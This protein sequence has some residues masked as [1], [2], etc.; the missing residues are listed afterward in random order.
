MQVNVRQLALAFALTTAVSSCD[1]SVVF[2]YAQKSNVDSEQ[3][4]RKSHAAWFDALLAGDTAAL[5]QLLAA[6]VTLAFPGGNLMPRA[7]FLSYLKSGEL[8]YDTAE[9]ED[10]LVRIYGA[11]GVVTG[12]STLGYR[13]K[14]KPGVERL[15]YTA[16]YART[17]T[18]WWLVAWH[19]TIR[20]E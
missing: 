8:F 6:D 15:R 1:R 5:E 16:V 13:F 19:S 7:E 2:A 10:M 20:R 3:A 12:R 14:G 18:R 4:V 9:H 11:T 17:D